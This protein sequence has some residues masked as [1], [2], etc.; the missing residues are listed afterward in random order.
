MRTRKKAHEIACIDLFCGVGGLSY[1]LK[2]AGLT[3]V[4]GIDIDSKCKY[5]YEKNLRADFICQD[6]STVAADDL[7]D[8]WGDSAYRVLA[9]CAPCQPFSTYSQRYD[10]SVS[11]RRGLLREFG[12][13]IRQSNPDVVA[14]E[15]VPMLLDQGEF[16]SFVSLLKRNGYKVF[17]EVV[18]CVEYGLAQTRNRLVLLASLKKPIA[19]VKPKR[20]AAKTLREVIG[21]LPPIGA[22]QMDRDDYLHTASRLTEINL[23]RIKASRPGGTWRDWPITLRAKCHTNTSGK[24]YP[25][26]YGRMEWDKPAPTLTTQ[27]YGFG[28]GRFGHPEQHRAITLREGALIQGFP[29]NYKFVQSADEV[30]FS[31]LG[32]LIGNAVPVDLAHHIGKSIKMHIS[33]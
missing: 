22:G 5:A 4:S 9:G 6:V 23:K 30:E 14:M 24:T 29:L 20:Q 15:N 16:T 17:Y 31:T 11:P 3:I 18:N 26:V 2:E 13:L 19:L 27:F 8:M 25:A 10:T 21:N 32:R 28:N 33:G 12:R 1:G 7:Y